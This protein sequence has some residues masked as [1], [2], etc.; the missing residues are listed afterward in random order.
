[1]L[2]LKPINEIDIEPVKKLYNLSFPDN[3]RKPFKMILRHWKKGKSELYTIRKTDTEE[4]VGLAFFMKNGE[5]ILFDYLAM[6]PE[7]RNKG[8]GAIVL[9]QQGRCFQLE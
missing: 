9:G 2:I 8:Y 6:L 5:D 3:E 4:F 7:C 1:M